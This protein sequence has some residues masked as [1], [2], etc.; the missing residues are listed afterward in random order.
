MILEEQPDGVFL[1]GDLLPRPEFK[2][3]DVVDFLN[4]FIREKFKKIK[5]VTEEETKIFVIMGNDDPKIFEKELE[6]LDRDGLLE[7]VNEET[8]KFRNLFVTGYSFV[9]PTPFRLK[10]WERYDVSRYVGV[11]AVSPENGTRTVEISDYKEK[12]GTIEE[13][14]SRL[15]ENSPLEKT[16][17]LFH[18][19]P[20][21]TALDRA[22]LD[23]KEV[24]HAPVDVHVGSI[25]IKRFI[26]EKQPLLTLH[27]H[28][29]ETVKLTGT[30]EE[31]IG[32]TFSFTGAHEEEELVVVKFNTDRLE[33]STR[34]TI[35]Y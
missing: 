32:D 24:D 29:H 18:S 3:S 15:A 26:E 16:I 10:D 2:Q 27:G 31:K 23:D 19:P 9:P 25:A 5:D 30:W 17:F 8:R 33:D 21:D 20:Y 1:G 14:L 11:G 13:D 28:V 4:D 6:R 22:D 34:D 35:R 7:Y 12:Y